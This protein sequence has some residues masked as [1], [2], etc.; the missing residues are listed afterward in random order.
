MFDLI[1][2]AAPIGQYY[3]DLSKTEI[4]LADRGLAFVAGGGK[5]E[6]QRAVGLHCKFNAFLLL[7][8]HLN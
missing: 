8:K 3:A 1:L 6:C 7:C 4:L 2:L 5:D